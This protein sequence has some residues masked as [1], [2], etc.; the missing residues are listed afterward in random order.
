MQIFRGRRF[1]QHFAPRCAISALKKGKPH[2]II[3]RSNFHSERQSPSKE[4]PEVPAFVGLKTAAISAIPHPKEGTNE[5]ES[6]YP[7]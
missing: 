1:F 6:L 5:D 2:P 4:D 7:D 3:N